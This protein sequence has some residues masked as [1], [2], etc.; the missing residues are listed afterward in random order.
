VNKLLRSLAAGTLVLCSLSAAAEDYLFNGENYTTAAGS[1]NTSMRLTGMIQTSSPIP[2]NASD[3]DI[4]GLIDSFSFSD[5]VNTLTEAN[6][7]LAPLS[8]FESGL[9]STD[10]D[11]EITDWVFVVRDLPIADAVSETNVFFGISSVL[12][13]VEDI[14]TPAA[15]C[16]S[17]TVDPT[18][19]QYDYPPG[20]S[21]FA[22][23]G[24][25]RKQLL[26]GQPV[27]TLTG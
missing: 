11:G 22:P 17:I 21:A 15:E 6:A 7:T 25:W 19:I 16:N 2:P 4:L 12:A 9:V 23:Q 10:A 1:Y 18:C 8:L 26:E 3:L 24:S 13:F 20:D 5:G 27:P 14:A